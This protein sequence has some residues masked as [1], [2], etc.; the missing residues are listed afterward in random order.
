MSAVKSLTDR[1]GRVPDILATVQYIA[2]TD[3]VDMT[4]VAT[5][6]GGGEAGRG[7]GRRGGGGDYTT[8]VTI[9][10]HIIQYV[11]WL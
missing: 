6:C 1:F 5:R 4:R 3:E 7:E 11:Q 8:S 2:S 9:D 10:G